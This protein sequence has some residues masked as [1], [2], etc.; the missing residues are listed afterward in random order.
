MG[1]TCRFSI[2]AGLPARVVPYMSNISG[3]RVWSE[4]QPIYRQLRDR[5]VAMILD[6]EIPEGEPVPSVRQIAVEMQINP[7]TV[8]KAMQE[9]SDEALL[10]KRRGL[11]M[12]VREGAR[13]VLLQRERERFLN[14]EW[15]MLLARIERMGLDVATLLAK[16]AGT[17]S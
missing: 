1:S 17:Q 3:T 6:G 7:L 2:F 14:D 9:L 10:E 4:G 15:P 8:S 13:S 11:G 16:P 5:I 12:Y